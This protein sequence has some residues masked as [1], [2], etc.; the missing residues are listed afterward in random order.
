M[1]KLIILASVF[2]LVGA[3]CAKPIKKQVNN[4]AGNTVSSA[5]EAPKTKEFKIYYPEFLPE[6]LTLNKE[7]ITEKL[8]SPNSPDKY[9]L[10]TLGEQTDSNKPYISI[11]QQPANGLKEIVKNDSAARRSGA[12]ENSK[13][14]NLNGIRYSFTDL[15][16]NKNTN[17]ILFITTGDTYIIISAKS[18]D[19]NFDTLE[20]IAESMR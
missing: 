8:I 6:G 19:F 17:Q 2:L 20:K 14:K 18:D 5:P 3:G 4:S 9:V 15:S 10:Y 7:K 1:R 13:L 16:T 11:R 12:I